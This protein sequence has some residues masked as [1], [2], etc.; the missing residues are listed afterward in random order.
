MPSYSAQN[1]EGRKKVRSPR[2]LLVSKTDNPYVSHN[3]PPPTHPRVCL[4]RSRSHSRNPGD[5]YPYFLAC[6]P[7]IE[8]LLRAGHTMCR[9]S[10]KHTEAR[11]PHSRPRTKP[12]T[13][14]LQPSTAWRASEKLRRRRALLNQPYRRQSRQPYPEVLGEATEL[15]E[16]LAS[17][18][19]EKPREFVPSTERLEMKEFHCILQVKGVGVGPV[20][21]A[22][23]NHTRRR[24]RESQL[25]QDARM[26][27]TLERGVNVN[28]GN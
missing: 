17:A 6:K 25:L 27:I 3:K 5:A 16:G 28:L 20:P 8:T 15:P 22:S 10:A 24:R 12:L 21:V 23:S 19:G 26:K 13:A 11:H 4:S 14:V 9:V 1:R 18:S 7:E 2:I